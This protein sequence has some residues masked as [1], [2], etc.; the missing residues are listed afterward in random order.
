MKKELTVVQT[1]NRYRAIQYTAFAGEFLSIIA[2][3]ITLGAVYFD[4]WF[5]S[6]DGWKVGLGGSLA[7]AIL[8]LAIYLFSKKKENKEITSGYVSLILGW[9]A[10]TFVIFLL[11]S[12]LD[13]ISMIMF[14]G[15]LGLCG[16]F[17]LDIVSN[18]Y[19][20]KANELKSIIDEVNKEETKESYRQQMLLKAKK[21]KTVKV[22]IKE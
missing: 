14:F 12:I 5:V 20:E 17:G 1:K 16:A 4:E 9:F 22:R 8:G 18:K 13:Q 3:Y 15:G 11:S 19:K 2:P 21:E 10:C 6:E 7:M